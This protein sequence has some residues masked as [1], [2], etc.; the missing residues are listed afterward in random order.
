LTIAPLPEGSINA[1]KLP[2]MNTDSEVLINRISFSVTRLKDLRGWPSIGAVEAF[3]NSELAGNFI[4]CNVQEDQMAAVYESLGVS[5]EQLTL[6]EALGNRSVETQAEHIA[7]ML[8]AA[9][10]WEEFTDLYDEVNREIN[11]PD[12]I[13]RLSVWA[14]T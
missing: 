9:D 14:D 4:Y 6:R 3:I 5:A 7:L 13:F 8:E 11:Y 12:N 2:D 1:L 10:T